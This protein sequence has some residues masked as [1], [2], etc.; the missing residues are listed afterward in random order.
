M[1]GRPLEE[2]AEVEFVGVPKLVG[3]LLHRLQRVQKL[4]LR[5][6]QD[7][8]ANQLGQRLDRKSVV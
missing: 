8:L 1:A 7:P 6:L 3:D 4:P 2:A 5:V